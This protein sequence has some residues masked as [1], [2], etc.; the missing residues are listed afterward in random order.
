MFDPENKEIYQKNAAA[1]LKQLDELD[2]QINGRCRE[3]RAEKFIVYHPAFGYLADDYGLRCMPS[4]EGGKGSDDSAP[5][6][7]GRPRK[8]GEHKGDLLSG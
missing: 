5:A 2:Q 4:R 3:R 8:G 6:G 1:Y 7:Y